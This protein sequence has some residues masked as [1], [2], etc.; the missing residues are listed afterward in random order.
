MCLMFTVRMVCFVSKHERTSDEESRNGQACDKQAPLVYE[1]LRGP[2]G[3][4]ESRG[5]PKREHMQRGAM[6]AT[7]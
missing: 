7:E 6:S 4:L 2:T 1:V 5:Y 3:G